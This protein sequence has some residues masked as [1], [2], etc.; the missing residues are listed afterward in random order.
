[1][2]RLRKAVRATLVVQF[3]SLAGAALS[4]IAVPLYLKWLGAERYGLMLT[5][6]ACAGYLMFSDAGLSWASMLLI[7]QAHGREDR[8]EIARIVRNSFT[9]AALSSLLVVA[10]LLAA[11]ILLNYQ[12]RP[13]VRFLGATPELKGLAL[14]IGFQVIVSL[15]FSPVYN[16]LIGL[17]E[18][19]LSALYQGIGRIS[20]T[21]ASM[22]FAARGSSLAVIMIA[23]SLCAVAS[24]F[25]CAIHLARRHRWVFTLGSL[26]DRRQ[27]VAQYRTGAKSFALQIGRV[28]VGSAPVFSISSQAGARFVPG[29]TVPLTLLNTPLAVVMSF[30]ATLQAG[31]GEAIGRKDYS[32]VRSTLRSILRNVLLFQ[33]LLV[34]G[35]VTL[36]P[37]VIDLWTRG[38]L[39]LSF[40]LMLSVLFVGLSS[41]IL[42]VF[43]F[44]LSGANRHRVAGLSEIANG[45]LC[46]FLSA[47][48]VRLAGYEWVGAGILLAALV[49]SAWL[50]PRQIQKHFELNDLWPESS[51]FLRIILLGACFVLVG[52]GTRLAAATT[53][54]THSWWGVC[55]SIVVICGAFWGGT[56]LAFPEDYRRLRERLR[57]G[58]RKAS[59]GIDQS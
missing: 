31:Y 29:F 17:Q 14:A 51:F 8:A 24:G 7:A 42:S 23:A 3:F 47:L 27:M 45:V 38:R 39:H 57:P 58:S 50:L 28:L 53:F 55:L 59:A 41:S 32:W 21:L 48:A 19:H 16:I 33:T 30:N 46:L 26:W 11:N 18:A 43:Q 2:S 34:A 5:A 12:W 1:M 35:F 44:A 56:R 4:L 22:Y 52:S 9:V 15:G 49:T 54:P 36:A 25:I 37:E 13:L 10:L 40:P 20:G 6:F